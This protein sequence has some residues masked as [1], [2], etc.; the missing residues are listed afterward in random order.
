MKVLIADDD[1][2]TV[3]YLSTALRAKGFEID[4]AADAMQVVMKA[5]RLV[6]DA[7]IMDIKMPA[8]T[9][10]TA[11]RRIKQSAK[12]AEVPVIAITGSPTDEVR[13][14]VH[15]LGALD[16]LEKPVDVEALARMLEELEG[17]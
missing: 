1:P 15:D 17:G 11:L 2:T 3:Q 4:T 10:L 16:C 8:G 6:P 7:I 5:V 13:R 12:T 14:E 9:G